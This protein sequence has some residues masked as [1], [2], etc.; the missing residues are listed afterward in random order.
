MD[1]LSRLVAGVTTR[2]L[3]LGAAAAVGG[4]ALAGEADAAAMALAE[5]FAAKSETVMRLGRAAF[6]RQNDLD[7]R[8]SIA[9]AVED[10]CNVATTPAAQE[11]LAAF[12]EKRK[13]RW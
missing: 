6:M 13:P 4:L 1:E 11:G 10:F 12:V 7:Y 5:T 3:A 2:R 8:R 9:N